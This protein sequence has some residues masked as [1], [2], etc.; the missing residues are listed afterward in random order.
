MKTGIKFIGYS[1]RAK[2]I[3]YPTVVLVSINFIAFIFGSTY[4]GGDAVNG[5]VQAGHYFVCE[6]G[7]CTEV[8]SVAWNYSYW[9][10][11]AAFSGI[12]LVFAEVALFLNTGDIEW[13]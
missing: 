2:W 11:W 5:Y 13:E 9:H 6:H 4:L 12:I 1:K 8:S 3:I 10:A 7:A